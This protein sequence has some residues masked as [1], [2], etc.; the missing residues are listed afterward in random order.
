M[1][2]AAGERAMLPY[3]IHHCFLTTNTRRNHRCMYSSHHPPQPAVSGT[4]APTTNQPREMSCGICLNYEKTIAFMPCGHIY[5]CVLCSASLN[6]CPMCRAD[7]I[8]KIK[9]YL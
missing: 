3:W 5:C 8:G 9:I 1:T 7:I 4:D 6:K 2:T